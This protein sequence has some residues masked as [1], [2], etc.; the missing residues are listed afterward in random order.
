M[1]PSIL[2]YIDMAISSIFIIQLFLSS[3]LIANFLFIYINFLIYICVL[4]GFV[5][6]PLLGSKRYEI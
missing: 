2:Y 3:I 1:T 5:T 6:H 4:G